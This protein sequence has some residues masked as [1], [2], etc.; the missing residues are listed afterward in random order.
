MSRPWEAIVNVER[1]GTWADYAAWES[2]MLAQFP[3]DA[4]EG[5]RD[6]ENYKCWKEN[7]YA[8]FARTVDRQTAAERQEESP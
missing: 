2:W 5:Y 4:Q 8:C 1:D 3:E 7:L 6:A